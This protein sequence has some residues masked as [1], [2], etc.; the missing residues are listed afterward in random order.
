MSAALRTRIIKIGKSQGIRIPRRLLGRI[1]PGEEVELQV[2]HDEIVIRRTH[3]P[4]RGWE[5]QFSA[6]AQRADDELLDSEPL[7]QTAWDGEEWQW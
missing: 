6:T 5:G 1:Q 7:L 2:Q 4:R 3:P